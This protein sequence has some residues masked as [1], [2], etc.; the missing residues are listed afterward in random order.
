MF[1][2]HVC[3]RQITFTSQA[4]LEA[5]PEFLTIAMAVHIREPPAWHHQIFQS[6][7]CVYLLKHVPL[8]ST[9]PPPPPHSGR[10]GVQRTG[11]SAMLLTAASDSTQRHIQQIV[12]IA[13]G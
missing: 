6:S 11:T 9:P 2:V 1:T 3:H 4:R 5:V 13:D 12:S 10:A 7:P 8:I